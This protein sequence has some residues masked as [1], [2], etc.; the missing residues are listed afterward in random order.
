V[1]AAFA[2]E[3]RVVHGAAVVRDGEWLRSLELV[4]VVV[5]RDGSGGWAGRSL[6][7]EEADA[8]NAGCLASPNLYYSLAPEAKRILVRV[9]E[10]HC[11]HEQV[12]RSMMAEP[13]TK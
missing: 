6:Y 11:C 1:T 10:K 2:K 4:A 9:F 12:A 3:P 13:N 7:R 8:I 5:D